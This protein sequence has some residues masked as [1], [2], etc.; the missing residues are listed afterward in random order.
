MRVFLIVADSFGIGEM[1]DSA[2]FGDEGVNTLRSC[3]NT[4]ELNVPNLTKLGLFNIDGIDFG[5]KSKNPLGVYARLAEK[6]AGKDTTVGHWELAGLVTE[7]P[8]PTYPNGFSGDII[9]EFS[10]AVGRNV[11]CNKPYS[12]T[13]VLLD[14]GRE[15]I[16]TGD[17]IVYTSAD[18]VFQVAAHEDIVSVDELY[19][20]CTVARNMLRSEHGVAR[21][22]ARPFL[23]EHPNFYRTKNR[24]D[25]SL[26]PTGETM[27]DKLKKSGK[28]VYA[29]G[30]IY[31]IFSGFGITEYVRTEN[32]DE[33]MKKT[34][35]ALD[36]D[37]DGLCFV[38]LVDFD[39]TYG[40]RRD[41]KGYA[42]A[43]SRFD[44]QLGELFDKSRD[45]DVFIITADHGCDPG[46]IKTTD[47]TR[48]YVPLIVWQK[49]IEAKNLG[50]L[51][52]LDTVSR[53]VLDM[54][55]I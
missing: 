51:T 40:H 25:F 16:K 37:F 2:K 55:N 9:D 53:M 39:M 7:T 49:G 42:K 1:A 29:I 19:D 30:K 52:G 44:N 21:V 15:H 34:I 12:G 32:N 27:L 26:A 31:D 5:E 17:L 23:G 6:S 50:T 24:H 46:Y 14:F 36:K 28:T 47:H 13:K 54:F 10:R 33:G 11:L 20:I 4:K 8:L 38:N 18:S 45:G 22:I 43:L 48:E 35:E 3:F 41:A